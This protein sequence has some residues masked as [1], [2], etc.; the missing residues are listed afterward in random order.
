MTLYRIDPLKDQRWSKFLDQHPRASVFHTVAWLE[1]LHETYGYEPVGYTTSAPGDDLQNGLVFCQVDSWITGRRLVSL[2]FSDHCEPLV[3]GAADLH[4]F[5][6]ALQR[7]S[8]EKKWRYIEIRPLRSLDLTATLFQRSETYCFHQLDISPTLDAIFRNFHKDS[9]QRKVRRAEREGLTE[10]EGRSGP[11][12]D[13][14]YRLQL[15]TRRRHNLPPQPRTW[16]R[17]LVACLGEGLK[18]RVAFK[19]AQPIAS[20]LTLSY[21]D[22]LVYKYGCSDIQFN[23]LGGMHLLFWKAIQDGKKCGLRIFDLGRS[24]VDNRGLIVFKD[25][26]GAQRSTLT[27]ARYPEGSSQSSNLGWKMKIVKSICAH[28]P[29]SFLTMAGN[30]FYK[31]IG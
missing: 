7:H 30:L 8:A 29:D 3:D 21:K 1:A 25:R 26:W 22:T 17:N 12:L 11:L 15:L 24:D 4:E 2:P 18:I 23:N 31:H 6:K 20:I 27:Y 19:G 28:A 5:L 9:T 14:F 13:I 10:E 16:F